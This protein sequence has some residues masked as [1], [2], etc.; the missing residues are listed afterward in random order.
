MGFGRYRQKEY[1]EV[2]ESYQLW[3]LAEV[4]SS[5]AQECHPNLTRFVRWVLTQEPHRDNP[6]LSSLLEEQAKQEIV[7]NQGEATSSKAI[8]KTG[9]KPK[10]DRSASMAAAME[11]ETLSSVSSGS[12][13]MVGIATP[14]L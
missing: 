14:P 13:Q 9:A 10:S 8:L 2:P 7:V 4:Q 1:R 3:A 6:L 11:V 12:V 5:S